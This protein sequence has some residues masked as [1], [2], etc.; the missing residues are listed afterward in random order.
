MRAT[1]SRG[2]RAGRLGTVFAAALWATAG[3][4]VSGQS[5]PAYREL[6][7]DP[8]R[9]A[10]LTQADLSNLARLVQLEA[11]SMLVRVRSEIGVSPQ[12]ERLQDQIRL[13]WDA[14]DAFSGALSVSPD[15]AEALEAA[16]LTYVDLAAAYNR[17]RSTLGTL[18]GTA[19]LTSLSLRNLARLM[20]VIPPLLGQGLQD[21]EA[22]RGG[23]PRS[24][25]LAEQLQALSTAVP[26]LRDR[27]EAA[28]PAVPQDLSGEL[29]HLAELVRGLGRIL[30][31]R[32]DEPDVA[33]AFRPL[34][35]RA[36]AIDQ[37]IA[38][39]SL[40]EAIRAEWRTVQRQV[41]ELGDALGFPREI[42]RVL[43]RAP[44]REVHQ[45]LADLID[46]ATEKLETFL[47]SR[48]LT[49]ETAEE[50]DDAGDL[51]ADARKLRTRLLLLRQELIGIAPRSQID[52]T[53]REVESAG[54]RLTNRADLAVRRPPDASL[55]HLEGIGQSIAK[56][57]EQVSALL[58]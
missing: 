23:E 22:E 32:A 52:R 7:E 42:V 28:G 14:A 46:A 39:S 5:P 51:E 34:R 55:S 43:P 21:F 56:I 12:G 58:R 53:L 24:A 15:P 4:S 10:N 8:P 48:Q 3:G 44:R 19:P 29:D 45:P 6:F 35:A 36:L 11:R 57:Q 25:T 9:T 13:L 49:L 2:V 17:I 54:R 47:A 18:P 30:T 20:A 26:Q 31:L 33:S 16:R 27:L 37:Q 1:P 38:E 41:D 40:P 50:A